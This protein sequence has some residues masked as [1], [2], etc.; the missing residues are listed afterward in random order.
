VVAHYFS[1]L[2]GGCFGWIKEAHRAGG[3]WHKIKTREALQLWFEAVEG[4]L[5]AKELA[6]KRQ[7]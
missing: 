1:L 6:I 7:A 4:S 5:A 3:K 2:H